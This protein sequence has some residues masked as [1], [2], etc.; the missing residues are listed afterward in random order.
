MRSKVLV[1]VALVGAAYGISKATLDAGAAGTTSLRYG[2]S[3][4][5]GKG[6]ARTYVVADPQTGRPLEV[7]VALT[8]AA[9]EGLPTTGEHGGNGHEHYTSSILPLPAGHGTP[10]RFVELNWNPT[11]HGGPYT[12][13][14]FDFHFYRITLE[15]HDAIDP[16]RADYAGQAAAFPAPAELPAGY[17]SSHV[18]MNLAPAQAS[19][20]KMGLHWLDTASPELPPRNRPFT[21]TFIVGSWGGKVIFDEPMVTRAFILA[22][23]DGG[24]AGTRIPVAPAARYAPAGYY[25]DSYRV[26]FDRGTR[27]YRVALTGLAWRK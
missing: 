8:E 24:T 4:E 26:S 10:Y 23:R 21:A 2:G 14:H 27:E 15:E 12:A 3:V 1:A 19:V 6:E 13:P 22:Q 5:L 16:T 17:V 11:G 18:L 7:G 9:L 25:M 20:P